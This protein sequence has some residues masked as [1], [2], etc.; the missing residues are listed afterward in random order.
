MGTGNLFQFLGPNELN[1]P[2]L[3]FNCVLGTFRRRVSFAER[4]PSLGTVYREMKSSDKN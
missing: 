4:R 3:I 2:S 1:E